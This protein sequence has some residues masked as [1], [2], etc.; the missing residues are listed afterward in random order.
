M[1]ISPILD[2]F[3]NRDIA[4]LDIFWLRDESLDESDNFSAPDGLAQ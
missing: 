3:N 2:F 4:S 1:R